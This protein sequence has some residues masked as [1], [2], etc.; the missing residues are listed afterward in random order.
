MHSNLQAAIGNNS[1]HQLQAPLTNATITNLSMQ[2]KCLSALCSAL[3]L[4]LQLGKS[5]TFKL[6]L[7]LQL[8][9]LLC[10]EL[11]LCNSF[12]LPK[13]NPRMI[14]LC[15]CLSLPSQKASLQKKLDCKANGKEHKLCQVILKLIKVSTIIPVA[16]HLWLFPQPMPVLQFLQLLGLPNNGLAALCCIACDDD[17]ALSFVLAAQQSPVH[18]SHRCEVNGR[19]RQPHE[20]LCTTCKQSAQ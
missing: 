16:Q 12:C 15:L 5:F 3:Y 19:Q 8:R 9:S 18:A 7:T 11:F 13:A 1:Q 14:L 4:R 20:P 17:A 2:N 6:L 10:L